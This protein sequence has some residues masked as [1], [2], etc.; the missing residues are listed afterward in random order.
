[1]P[2]SVPTRL[3]Q[4]LAVALLLVTGS[5]CQSVNTWRP[6]SSR[7][8]QS[9]EIARQ[10]IAALEQGRVENA[11]KQLAQAL[12]LNNKAEDISDIRFH[13]AEALW[14]RGKQREALAQL[15]ILSKQRDDN[16][17]VQNSLAEK[18][19][20]LH[21][22]D[23]AL[24]CATRATKAVPR[25][26]RGWV[27]RGKAY[28]MLADK[29]A[30]KH[31]DV[32]AVELYKRSLADLHRSVAYCGQSPGANR[33]VLPELANV[34]RILGQTEQ[35]LATWQSLQQFYPPN[36]FPLTL[37]YRKAE[38][39]LALDRQD[40]AD[41]LMLQARNRNTTEIGDIPPFSR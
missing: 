32:A 23:A 5:G 7:V 31:E 2:P 19:L 16:P 30:E 1:M 6:A 24:Q 14:Q 28:R 15:L 21:E 17:E 35:E 9:R 36:Q 25:D 3:L 33:E 37:L 38:T 41:E 39:L 11:E 12:A 26:Y 34:Q 4:L 18:L 40:D 8:L 20:E 29:R 10:G 13:Y 27:Y 22:A